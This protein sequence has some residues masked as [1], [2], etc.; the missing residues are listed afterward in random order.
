MLLDIPKAPLIFGLIPGHPV[1]QS[2]R[3]AM[4]ISS[5]NPKGFLQ[6]PISVCLLICAAVSVAVTLATRRQAPP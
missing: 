3:Q 4:S 2:F 1:E 5:G 6:S